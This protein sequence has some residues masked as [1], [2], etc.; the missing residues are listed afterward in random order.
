VKRVAIYCGARDGTRPVFREAATALGKELGRRKIGIV[1]GGARVG[2]MG[3]VADAVLAEGAEAVGVLPHGLARAEFAHD[4][5]TALHKVDTMH[6]RKAMME[7]LAEGF[8]AMPGGFGTLDELFEIATWLQVGLHA[9]PIGLLNV[10]GYWSALMQQVQRGI[11]EGFIPQQLSSA[12]VIDEQPA[13]LIDKLLAHEVPPS[14][15]KWVGGRK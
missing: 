13:A 12:L 11:D 1:Y 4:R 6:E 7:Q 15:V 8:I 10:D 9:K 2:L 5:L 14:V 3:A